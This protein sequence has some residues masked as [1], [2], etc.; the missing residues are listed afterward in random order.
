MTTPILKLGLPWSD[1]NI[2]RTFPMKS[3]GTEESE[4]FVLFYAP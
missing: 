3:K 2:E 1:L 4:V